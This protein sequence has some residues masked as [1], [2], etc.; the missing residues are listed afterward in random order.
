MANDADERKEL[1]ALLSRPFLGACGLV[2]VLAGAVV[3]DKFIAIKD[4]LTEIRVILNS[5][6]DLPPRTAELER[7]DADKEGRLREIERDHWRFKTH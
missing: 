7:R 6:A 1:S 3:G 2:I 4:D 5:R